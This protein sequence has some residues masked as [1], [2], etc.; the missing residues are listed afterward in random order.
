L[1]D[2]FDEN[3][4]HFDKNLFTASETNGFH[5]SRFGRPYF[6]AVDHPQSIGDLRDLCNAANEH[7]RHVGAMEFLNQFIGLKGQK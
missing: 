1:S 3:Q 5:S 7:D 6:F 2:E 4:I